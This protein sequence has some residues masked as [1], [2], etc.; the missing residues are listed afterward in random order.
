MRCLGK[1]P[2]SATEWVSQRGEDAREDSAVLSIVGGLIVP[3]GSTHA[4]ST[5]ALL[6]I[7]SAPKTIDEQDIAIGT[8]LDL[9]PLNIGAPQCPSMGESSLMASHR[10]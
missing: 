3:G 4:S 5:A 6:T 7:L 1:L 10:I 9:Q 2:L 8:P